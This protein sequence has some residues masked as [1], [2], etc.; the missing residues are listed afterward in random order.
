MADMMNQMTLA[1]PN[2]GDWLTRR[3]A[4]QVLGVSERTVERMV[5]RRTLTEHRPNGADGERVPGMFWAA[6]VLRAKAAQ[7]VLSKPGPRP[8]TPAS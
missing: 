4:A 2:P 8:G 7:D 6:E 1:I 5:K 3:G